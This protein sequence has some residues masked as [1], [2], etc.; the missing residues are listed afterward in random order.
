[1]VSGNNFFFFFFYLKIYKKEKFII[2]VQTMTGALAAR[3]DLRV[4]N[5]RA[6]S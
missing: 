3:N 2:I 1:M 4:K 5:A 6:A